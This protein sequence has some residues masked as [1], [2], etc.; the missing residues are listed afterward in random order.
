MAVHT[1]RVHYSVKYHRNKS[2]FSKNLV[3]SIGDKGKKYM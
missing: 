1:E 3:T 2:L